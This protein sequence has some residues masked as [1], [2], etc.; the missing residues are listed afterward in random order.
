MAAAM[1]VGLGELDSVCLG[2]RGRVERD[3]G[4]ACCASQRG[5]IGATS[6]LRWRRG[7]RHDALSPWRFERPSSACAQ[8]NGA[9]WRGREA[10][11]RN[12]GWGGGF[13]RRAQRVA[14]DAGVVTAPP[15]R[16]RKNR[17]GRGME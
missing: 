8:G 5:R 15:R 3:V 12:R 4:N 6:Q 17:G 7:A 11:G 9:A 10:S 2:Q 14:G 13:G 16:E 1:A